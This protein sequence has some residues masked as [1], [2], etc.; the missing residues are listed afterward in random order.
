MEGF[1]KT[2]MSPFVVDASVVCCWVLPD[3]TSPIADAALHLLQTSNA[4]APDLLWH[5]V[6]NVLMLAHRRKRID[7]ELVSKGILILRGLTIA[8]IP[9]SGDRLI[10]TLAERHRLTAYDA[11]YLA[12]ALEQQLPLATLDRELAQAAVREHVPLLAKAS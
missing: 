6:R 1:R 12:L 4:I 3:E 9:P 11:A 10:L 2:L 7:F 8:T 5:E